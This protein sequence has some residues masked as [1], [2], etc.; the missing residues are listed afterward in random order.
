V[1]TA[2][3]A[4]LLLSPGSVQDGVRQVAEE[5]LRLWRADEVAVLDADRM[6]L[7]LCPDQPARLTVV[8]Q[9]VTSED[10]PT[11]MVPFPTPEA[12]T[13]RLRLRRRRGAPPFTPE[14]RRVLGGFAEQ[15]ATFLRRA[16]QRVEAERRQ[17]L[18][19]RERIARDL[20]DHVIGRLVGAGMMMKGLDR[21]LSDPAGQQCLSEGL[22]ELDAAVRDIRTSV[23]ALRD[24]D[25]GPVGARERIR[26]VIAEVT[27]RLGFEPTLTIGD[28]PGLFEGPQLLDNVVAVLRE[29]LTNVARHAAA[30]RVEVEV[31]RCASGGDRIRV[32]VSDDGR[33]T[34]RWPAPCEPGPDGGH[35]LANLA[36]RAR[37]LGGTFRAE[38]EPGKGSTLIWEVPLVGTRDSP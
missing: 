32:R 27:G 20:H 28:S 22:D 16:G 33:G 24:G 25:P 23:H 19:E 12:A 21:W 9:R 1:T 13:G 36:Y 10:G 38:G 37:A 7:L 6:L 8:G 14:D 4:A 5:A 34:A 2:R 29:S 30:R 26:Q 18:A 11:L 35:G 31:D 3:I 15:T 17:V